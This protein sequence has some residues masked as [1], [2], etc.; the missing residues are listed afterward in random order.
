MTQRIAW[1]VMSQEDIVTWIEYADRT[2]DAP[3]L[4]AARAA[5]VRAQRRDGYVWESRR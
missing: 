2:H 5:L 4:K 3:L 1:R